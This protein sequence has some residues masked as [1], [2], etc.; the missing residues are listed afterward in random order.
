MLVLG[1]EV[2][3]IT[4]EYMTLNSTQFQFPKTPQAVG[5]PDL[6]SKNELDLSA[7]V[8]EQGRLQ[9]HAANI[10]LSC[11]VKVHSQGQKSFIPSEDDLTCL[12]TAAPASRNMLASPELRS[13]R[14]PHK[15]FSCFGK[16][17]AAAEL[18]SSRS[19]WLHCDNTA[20][21]SDVLVRTATSR[22]SFKQ[23]LSV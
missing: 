13:G 8:S 12:H 10:R 18:G 22:S 19:G 9:Q 4:F 16:L 15:Q 6:E 3:P 7:E 21:H 14:L 17:R 23:Y 5:Q 11:C 1:N 2:F 20:Q